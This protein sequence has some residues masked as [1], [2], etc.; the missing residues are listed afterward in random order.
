MQLEHNIILI[1][2]IHWSL[3]P[4][5]VDEEA[6]LFYLKEKLD[7]V[8][9]KQKYVALVLLILPFFVFFIWDVVTE[10]FDVGMFFILVIAGGTFSTI[11]SRYYGERAGRITL[12]IERMGFRTECPNCKKEI[13]QEDFEFCP[14]CGTALTRSTQTPLP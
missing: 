9:R 13:P 11:V 5:N 2:S 7:D 10:T 14:Y 6:R 12:Q 3:K 4:M 1:N 8:K